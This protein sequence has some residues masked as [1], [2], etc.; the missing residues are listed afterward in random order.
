MPQMKLIAANKIQP[1]RVTA[2]RYRGETDVARAT[3]RLS[4][5]RA[6]PPFEATECRGRAHHPGEA[7]EHGALVDGESRCGNV[8]LH[9]RTALQLDRASG[10]DVP[11]DL[12]THDGRSAVDVRG[13]LGVFADDEQVVR[14]DAPGEGA[15]DLHRAFEMELAVDL[16]FLA[17]ECIQ[18]LS[19]ECPLD[20]DRA[21]ELQLAV[22]I[23]ITGE[24]VG[25]GGDC[26]GFFF[27]EDVGLGSAV[28][29]LIDPLSRIGALRERGGPT[30]AM[31]LAP[32]SLLN[33]EDTRK[34]RHLWETN[35][36][37]R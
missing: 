16:R 6:S 18:H 21:F 22:R 8:A 30:A 17:E 4:V 11:G 12:A 27:G 25:W 15:V 29:H 20:L 10:C 9:A 33:T 28:E 32:A 14:R 1:R 31:G 34:S 35:G 23:D 37:R 5:A 19:H 36:E 24:F 13:D 2:P 7:V 26:L 3:E